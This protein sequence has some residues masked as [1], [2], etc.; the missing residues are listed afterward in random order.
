MEMM[1]YT[2][3]QSGA[4]VA[5]P[6][7]S[8]PEEIGGTRN[9]DYRFTWIRDSSFVI[10]ALIRIGM[11][12][13]ADAY[14]EFINKRCKDANADGSLQIMYGIRGEKLLTEYTLD[15]LDGYRGS[16]P[17]RIGN[18]AYNHL[19]L[20][21]YGELL[22]GAYLFNKFGSPISYDM[23]CS[24]RKL[25]NYVCDNWEREDMSIWEVRNQKRHFIYSKVMCW[26]A[27]D[28]GKY[29]KLIT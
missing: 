20:D 25:V 16:K 2:T 10:Y 23:W 28:R 24:L 4:V 11:L 3:T 7:F 21:I 17:V 6:T 19:Q 9:W 15:H 5:A 29:Y 18:G 14:M 13:E 27:V 1:V 26:V 8:L 12:G 22:D